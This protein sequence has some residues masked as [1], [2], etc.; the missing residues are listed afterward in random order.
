MKGELSKL[1]IAFMVGSGV[2]IGLTYFMG[3]MGVEYNFG[4]NSSTLREANKLSELRGKITTAENTTSEGGIDISSDLDTPYTGTWNAVLGLINTP[5]IMGS[6]ISEL[7]NTVGISVNGG[8]FTAL[9]FGL[10]GLLVL[11]AVVKVFIGRSF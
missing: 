1:F 4:T 2:L 8:W 7:M 10:I 9:I 5:D 3:D 11:T 6:M